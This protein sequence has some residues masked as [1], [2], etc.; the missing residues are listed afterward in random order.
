MGNLSEVVGHLKKEL[1][2][3]QQDVQR[4]TSALAALGSSGSNEKRSL[5]ADGRKRISMAQKARRAKARKGSQPVAKG[6][7]IVKRT[8]SA[9][10]RKRI[11]AAQRAR[12]AKLKATKKAA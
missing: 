5:S 2:R 6:L 4:F 12:W 1:K 8:I 3:A 11:A 7:T 10:G 9:A